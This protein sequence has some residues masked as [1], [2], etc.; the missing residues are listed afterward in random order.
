MNS[1]SNISEFYDN[2][3]K[4]DLGEIKR[5]YRSIFAITLI[6]ALLGVIY[7]YFATNIYQSKML[8]ELTESKKDMDSDF[9]SMAMGM[10]GSKIEDEIII[11]K[12]HDLARKALKDLN[13]GTRYFTTKNFKHIE[14]YKDSPFVITHEY[15]SEQAMELPIKLIPVGEEKFRLIIEPTTKK[16]IVNTLRSFIAPLPADKQPIIYNKIHSFGEKIETPWFAFSVQKIHELENEEY[17]FTILPDRL[18]YYFIDKRLS[19]TTSSKT[20]N[21]ITL[22]F[23]DSVPLRAKEVLDVLSDTYIKEKMRINSK[24]ADK[25]LHFIDIQLDAINKMLESSSKSL[26]QYKATNIVVDLS[27]EAQLTA[28]KLSELETQLYEINMNIDVMESILNYIKTHKDI[29][30]VNMADSVQQANPAIQNIIL[31]IQKIT[32]ENSGLLAKY[33]EAH[34]NAI[35]IK[36]QLAS[37]RSSLQYTIQSSLRTLKKRKQ[38]LS[39][40]IENNRIKMQAFP[41]QEQKLAQLTRNFMVN[42]KIYSFLLEKRAEIAIIES[43]TV[44]EILIVEPTKSTDDIDAPIKPKRVLTILFGF[45]LGLVLGAAQALL[46]VYLDN[47]VKSVE[48]IE[49]LTTIPVYGVLPILKQKIIKLEVFKDPKSP[50]AESYRSLRTN[51]QFARK[52]NQANVILVTSNIAGEGKSTTTANL[53]AIFQMADYRSIVINLDLRRPTLHHYFNVDNSSGMSTYL[54]GKSNIGEI[55]QSTDYEQLDIIASGP[56]PPN[57]SELILTD[58][59]DKLLNDLKEVY[60]YIFIDSAPLGLVTDTMHLMQYAD[61]SLIVFRENYAKKSFVTDL[62]K[63]IGK[64]NLKHIGIV[65]NSADISSGSYGYGYGYNNNYSTI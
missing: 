52:E 41:E 29:K 8:L 53:G 11:F 23:E 62:N 42:E 31:E 32:V 13:L 46:R 40:T 54:S 63:L 37:L 12:T 7:A 30:G 65:I 45:F 21:I 9:M 18:M 51:L 24:S 48:D 33:T 5:Y 6:V 36:K 22:K 26:E 50:F 27:S 35:K 1:G 38:S 14:L 4:I 16:K 60:D 59:L 19:V 64:H 39:M 61:T 28:G 57:P 34:P 17:F 44:S 47:T 10:S 56:V 15:L 43:S 25:K 55:I 20:S 2:E 3:D 49:K 58:K